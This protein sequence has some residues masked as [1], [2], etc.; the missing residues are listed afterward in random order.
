MLPLF[1]WFRLVAIASGRRGAFWL[2]QTIEQLDNLTQAI[3]VKQ[4]F[5]CHC[6][7]TIGK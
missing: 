7:W 3:E 5:S 4:V 6:G 2:G 1:G